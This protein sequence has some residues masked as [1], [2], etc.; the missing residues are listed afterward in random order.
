MHITLSFLVYW[1]INYYFSVIFSR[2]LA[3]LFDGEKVVIWQFIYTFCGLTKLI[4]AVESSLKISPVLKPVRD[5]CENF[6]PEVNYHRAPF[7]SW[8]AGDLDLTLSK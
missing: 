5:V 7:S 4:N 6:Q 8:D 1:K 3:Q 2:I